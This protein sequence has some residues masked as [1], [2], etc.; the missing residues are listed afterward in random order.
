MHVTCWGGGRVGAEQMNASVLCRYNNGTC[1]PSFLPLTPEPQEVAC[2]G[3]FCCYGIFSGQVV[4]DTKSSGISMELVN[5]WVYCLCHLF[6]FGMFT[7]NSR[8]RKVE[9]VSRRKLW[10]SEQITSQ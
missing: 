7:N 4:Y 1:N 10:L 2:S 6:A 8:G 5:D 9:R 3:V